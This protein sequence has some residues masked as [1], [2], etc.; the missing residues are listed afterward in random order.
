MIPT[1]NSQILTDHLPNARLRIYPDA[2]HG[3]LFQCPR[4]FAELVAEFCPSHE[5]HPAKGDVAGG[6]EA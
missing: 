4:R 3:F 1:I 5:T 2:G 6:Q